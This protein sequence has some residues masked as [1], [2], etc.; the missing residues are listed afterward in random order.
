MGDAEWMMGSE[1]GNEEWK[2]EEG[3]RVGGISGIVLV[4]LDRLILKHT[5]GRC[6]S[7]ETFGEVE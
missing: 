1:I 5:A 6:W 3:G 7:R 2:M 4:L